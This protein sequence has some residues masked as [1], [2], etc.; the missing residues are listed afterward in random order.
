MAKILKIIIFTHNKCDPPFIFIMYQISK[1]NVGWQSAENPPCV[2]ARG[3]RIFWRAENSTIWP[4]L[5]E[6]RRSLFRSISFHSL[7][8][9]K[10]RWEV[11]NSGKILDTLKEKN[12][13]KNLK[14]PKSR[15]PFEVEGV[16]HSSGKG[17]WSQGL[18]LPLTSFKTDEILLS[19]VVG[20][21][22]N[23]RNYEVDPKVK[24]RHM[25]LY[26]LPIRCSYI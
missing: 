20:K 8:K 18:T 11:N 6:Y 24:Q 15:M 17:V 26:T 10:K 14:N 16:I 21:F 22:L 19:L 4:S 23:Q 1:R 5:V 25:R 13:K 2:Q 12:H 7:I 9:P 3:W